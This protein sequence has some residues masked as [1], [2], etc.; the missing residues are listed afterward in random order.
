MSL[1]ERSFQTEGVSLDNE[2]AALQNA[3][4]VA[5]RNSWHGGD[6]IEPEFENFLA[7]LTKPPRFTAATNLA[8]SPDWRGHR[9]RWQEAIDDNR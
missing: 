9:N 1:T 8:P 7:A 4:S 3:V 6:V 2:L 5:R